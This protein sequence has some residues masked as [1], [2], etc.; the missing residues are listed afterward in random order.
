MGEISLI[1][2]RENC[3]VDI[4]R[5]IYH[6]Q[7]FESLID[8]RISIN[9][10]NRVKRALM[11]AR[12]ELDLMI[13]TLQQVLH[14]KEILKKREDEIIYA[15]LI[16]NIGRILQ[17]VDEKETNLLI[18]ADSPTRKSSMLGISRLAS[19]NRFLK[20][21]AQA[22]ICETISKAIKEYNEFDPTDEV[23]KETRTF[24]YILFQILNSSLAVMGG[25]TREKSKINKR[26]VV[27]SFPMTYQ[28]MMSGEGQ[29]KIREAHTEETGE[30]MNIPEELTELIETEVN[31]NV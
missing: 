5:V 16:D 19:F 20:T 9:N 31:E 21:I 2:L 6:A 25:P 24:L 17:E 18:D 3:P 12:S 14:D 8:V 29:K 10:L 26:G 15:W 4:S 28:R 22:I 27:N 1:D 23:P 30:E 11:D 13:T 7:E